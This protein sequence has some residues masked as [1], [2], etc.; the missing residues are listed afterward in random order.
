MSKEQRQNIR[1]IKKYIKK[2]TEKKEKG[3]KVILMKLQS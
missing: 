1:I 3:N 2:S